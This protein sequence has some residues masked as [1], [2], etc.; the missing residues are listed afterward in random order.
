VPI[1]A[2]VTVLQT[3]IAL[4]EEAQKSL[5]SDSLTIMALIASPRLRK[6]EMKHNSVFIGPTPAATAAIG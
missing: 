4:S 2:L 5:F 3:L 1:Q 6:V